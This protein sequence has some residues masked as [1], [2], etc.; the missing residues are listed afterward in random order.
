MIAGYVPAGA[1]PARLVINPVMLAALEPNEISAVG[2]DTAS[3]IGGAGAP[4]R[5]AAAIKT[6]QPIA[7]AQPAAHQSA[8]VGGDPYSFYG[9]YEEC[10]A[11]QAD[12]CQACLPNNNCKAVTDTSDGNAECTTLAANNGKGYYELCINLALAI[13]R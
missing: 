10:A 9:S 13:R 2:V 12:R 6:G 4:P 3:A 8:A 5:T 11:A 1:Q 7:T